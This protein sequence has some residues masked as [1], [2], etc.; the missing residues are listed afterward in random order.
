[1]KQHG[2]AILYG[3]LIVILNLLYTSLPMPLV[4]S[5]I[6]I[7]FFYLFWIGIDLM[8]IFTFLILSWLNQQINS[9]PESHLEEGQSAKCLVR[10]GIY[11]LVFLL[12]FYLGITQA[13]VEALVEAI[14][15]F[16]HS[17]T[18]PPIVVILGGIFYQHLARYGDHPLPKKDRLHAREIAIV[19]INTILT[20]LVVLYSTLFSYIPLLIF[21]MLQLALLYGLNKG[22]QHFF[23]EKQKSYPTIYLLNKAIRWAFL[24][25]LLLALGVLLHMPVTPLPNVSQPVSVV[26][27]IL[28]LMILG[29]LLEKYLTARQAYN[30]A[31]VAL[32]V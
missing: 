6:D 19:V 8:P 18:T 15:E 26:S 21:S 7:F 11:A 3:M 20:I 27:N 14:I 4:T 30:K 17:P 29:H 31:M 24:P 32:E 22:L 2:R 28:Y 25:L 12:I 5:T 9:N 23:I 13:S 10:G 16:Q 1:M